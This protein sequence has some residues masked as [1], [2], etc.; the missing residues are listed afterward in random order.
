MQS[1]VFALARLSAPLVFLAALTAPLAA[2]GVTGG[3]IQGTVTTAGAAPVENA[4][5]TVTSAA[6]GQRYQATTRANGRYNVENI[7]LGG[8]FSVE[9]R[10]IGYEP[11]TRSGVALALGQR[12]TLD[13]ALAQ[14]AVQLEELTVTAQENPLINAGRTGAAQTISERAIR[15]L[16]LQGRNF[17]D[18][19][20]TSPQATPSSNSDGAITIAGQNNRYNNIQIDGGVNNDLFGLG[21][22]GAPGGQVLSKPISLEAVQEF[23]VLVAPFDVRQGNFAGG[24]VN[25]ITKSGTNR[26][27]GSVFSYYRNESLTGDDPLGNPATEFKQW[28]YGLTFGGPVVRDK[29]Q[30]F[31]AV[32]VQEQ[33]A[34]W[35][36]QQI[37]PDPTGGADSLGIG[38]TQ[39]TATRVQEIVRDQYG[40][41]PG[42][43][44]QPTLGLPDRNLFG[45]VTAQ[46]G[47]NS[48]LELSYNNV[49]AEREQLTRDA[50]RAATQDRDGYQL[51]RSGWIQA[52]STNTARAKWLKVFGGKLNNELLVGY[53]RIRDKRDQEVNTPLIRVQADRAGAYVAAGSDVF[54]PNNLLDQDVYEITDNLTLDVGAAHRV[55]V[56]THNE[57]FT[58]FNN[59]FPRSQGVWTF[60]DTTALKNNTPNRYA[61]AL[62][63]REGGPASDFAVQQF[64]LYAQDAWSPNNRLTLTLGVRADVPFIDSPVQN[65]ALLSSPLA[66]NTSDFP[67]GNILWSPRLGVNF[68][69]DGRGTTILRGGVGLFSGRP[70]YVW[71]SNAFGNTGTEQVQLTCSAPGTV[72][73]FT[74]DVNN[75]P[76]Q[77]VGATTGPTAPPADVNFFDPDFRFP[78]NLRVA[79]GVD[80]RLP[81]ELVGTFDFLYSYAVNDL[82]IEEVNINTVGA[83]A[84]EGGRTLYGTLSGSPT[85]FTATASRVDPAFRQVLRH[86]GRSGAY[87]WSASGQLQKQFSGAVDVN[88]A[89]TYSRGKDYQ[90]LTSSIAASNFQFAPL[91]GTIADRELQTSFFRVPHKLTLSGTVRIPV[92]L[93]PQFS[94]IYLGRSGQAFSYQVSSDI[95]AD[96][97]SGNDNLYIP[98]DASDISLAGD[99]AAQATAF[100]RLDSLITANACLNEQRG[101]IMER[102]SC[103]NPWINTLNARLAAFIPLPG[104]SLEISA[105]LFNMLNLLDG[106]WGLEKRTSQFETATL[107]RA[108]GFDAANNRPI[109]ALSFPRFDEPELNRS[110]WRLQLGA[111]YSF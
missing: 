56:G 104:Q 31:A 15:T 47:V 91:V 79:F 105:D 24:L 92:P 46:L 10:A 1:S 71:V 75:L 51:S 61:V 41:D 9:A 28:Q 107:L 43:W 88:A 3:A 2:Q 72:P 34:P 33:D 102:N 98:R 85:A 100:T 32:D 19:V 12:L 106:S 69:L 89:Y 110:R 44:R 80:R 111:R 39:I 50:L 62:P 49:D 95:N 48:R 96:G 8:E 29:V 73:A 64:G 30:F 81:W 26:F 52:N 36:G 94:L 35:G 42:D 76:T 20:A 103:R 4:V 66:I 60:A 40:F 99:A 7:A 86:I 45:K 38:I 101:R 84:A 109:Y 97:T 54:T 14:Q 67:S 27:S 5:V 22:T 17:T 57:F 65:P 58:F 68:D 6:S 108:A 18:L 13:L 11:A 70:P 93:R 83:S 25:A 78:Q 21:A 90:S 74:S 63:L 87:T 53:Q 55:T 37:G 23:Q 16:P 77:C 59:F 82:Y